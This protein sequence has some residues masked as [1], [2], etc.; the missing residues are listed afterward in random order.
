[1]ALSRLVPVGTHTL[2]FRVE[3]FNALNTFN[4]GD[5]VTNLNSGQF[6]RIQ[7][8]TGTTGNVVGFPRIMQFGVKYGF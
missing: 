6:G 5:P 8:M 2:E 1:V 4:W 7:T 3:A